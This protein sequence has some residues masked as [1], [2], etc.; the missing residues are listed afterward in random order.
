M[1]LDG[2]DLSAGGSTG[3]CSDIED[4]VDVV[5]GIVDDILVDTGTTIPGTIT[6]ID[7]Y[8]DIPGANVTTNT[9]MRDVIGN[10]TDAATQDADATTKSIISMIKGVLDVLYDADGVAAYPAAAAPANG[11]SMARV[12]R[13]VYDEVAGLDGAAMRGTD[14]AATVADGWDAALATILDNFSAARIGYLDELDFD[15]AAA[16]TSIQNEVDN[17]DGEAMRGTDNALLAASYVTERGTDGAA[18]ASSW[19]SAL[20]T[21]LGN[22]T[23][24]RA[25]YIDNLSAGAA[26]LEATLTA[27]KGD[28]W[29]AETLKAIYDLLDALMDSSETGDTL[30]AD[31]SEQVVY[32]QAS[33]AAIWSPAVIHI[34]LTNMAANDVITVREY[35]KIKSGGDYLLLDIKEYSNA[36]TR[37][38]IPVS[39][40]GRKNRWGYKVSLE[41]TAGTNRTY[42]WEVIYEA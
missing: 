16:L 34:D 8:H 14:S 30:T 18:L 29:T 10:K 7:G 12:L 41:Q 22:Y 32:E 36:Q 19:T 1:S 6:I 15:L 38:V 3:D 42:D 28:G 25:G 39:P 37:K 2:G 26:A 35:I 40:V 13:A 31:G 21:A 11:V 27:I 5:D 20:A 24:A 4:K 23:A 9:Q 33:P 17:L